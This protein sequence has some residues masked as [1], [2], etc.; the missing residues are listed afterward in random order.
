MANNIQLEVY[1]AI[2]ASVNA[3]I[4]SDN[5]SILLVDCLRNSEEAKAL[6]AIIKKTKKTA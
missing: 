2:E 6:A 4:F 3:Y 5:E 1:H